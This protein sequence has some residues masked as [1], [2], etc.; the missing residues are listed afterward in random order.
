MVRTMPL[1]LEKLVDGKWVFV[2]DV[3][4]NEAWETAKATGEKVRLIDKQ[5]KTI[6][7][8]WSPKGR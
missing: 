1:V 3:P 2:A 5:T 4:S 8:E 6:V 7:L